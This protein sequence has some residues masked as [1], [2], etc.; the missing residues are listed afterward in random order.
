ME[1]SDAIIAVGCGSPEP[2]S[3]DVNTPDMSVTD[4]WSESELRVIED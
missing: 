3:A 1:N 2:Q 4:M